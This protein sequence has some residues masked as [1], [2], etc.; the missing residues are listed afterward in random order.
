[1]RNLRPEIS[2]VIDLTFFVLEGFDFCVM[3]GNCRAGLSPF[4]FCEKADR[5]IKKAKASHI[6]LMADLLRD[7]LNVSLPVKK[8]SL[9]ELR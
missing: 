9:K 2:L 6:N 7:F 5:L 4:V 3:R 1:V 8:M